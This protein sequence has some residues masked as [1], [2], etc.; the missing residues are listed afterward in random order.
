M[1]AQHV[2]PSPD[3]RSRHRFGVAAAAVATAV[4]LAPVAAQNAAD[5]VVPAGD[6][7]A[8]GRDAA[9]TKHSPLSDIDRTSV[10]RLMLAWEWRTGERAIDETDST[11]A[12][13][14]GTFQATPLAIDGILYLST[15]YN[16]VVALDGASGRELWR[17]DPG[18]FRHGQPSNGTGFVHR[19]VA[20]WTDGTERRILLASRWQLIALDAATGR[21]IPSFG[22]AGIVDLTA[23]LARPI[24]RLHYT[25]TSPPVVWQDLVIV[26]NGVGDRL[27][28]PGDPGGDVQAFDARTGRRV[29]SFDPIPQPGRTGNETWEDGSW[30]TAGHTNVWAPMSVDEARGLV[31]LPVSTPSNDFYGGARKGDNLFA[32]SVVCLDA[33][34]GERRWHFQIAHHGVWDYDLPTAPV[35]ATVRTDAGARDVVVQLTKQG[36]AFVFDRVT[37]EPIWPIEERPV[38]QSD[39]PGERLA[40]TQPFPTKPAPFA[41]QGFSEDDVVDF[42]PALRALALR[43]VRPYRTGP[44][45]APPSRAGTILMPG[46]IGGSGWGGGA[47]DPRSNTLFV[48]ATNAPAVIRLHQPPPSDTILAAW[49]FDRG[50]SL[51]WPALT[52][53]DSAALGG[54]PRGIPLHKPPYGTLTAIDLATGEHRW[55]VPAGDEPDVR[56][57][58]LLAA[59][60]L[61]QLGTSGAPGPIVTAGG[62]VFLTGGGSVLYAHDADTGAVLWRADL[63]ANGYANPMTYLGRDGR[64]YIVIA[65][66]SGDDAVL[67]AFALDAPSAAPAQ[68]QAEIRIRADRVLDGRGGV[69]ED[70]IVTVEGSRIVRVER[71]GND[72]DV[73]YDLRGFTLMPG[74]IDTHVHMNWHFDSDGR[75]HDAREESPQQAILYAA[76]NAYATLMGGITTVQSLGAS[77]DGDLRDALA[78]GTLPG[79]RVLTSLRSLSDRTGTPDEIR[80]AVRRLKADRADVI[81]IF[82][83]ASIRDGGAATMSQAQLDAACGEARAQGLRSAVHAHGPESAQRAVRA[84]CTV[85]EHG[86][87]LDDAT[88]DLMAEHRTFYD[89]NIG[90]VLQNYLENRAQFEGVGNYDA[91]GFAHM[92]RAVPLALDAF[93][94]A[95]QRPGIRIVF[96]TDAVAGAHGRNF[97]EL[98]YRVQQG[99]QPPMA[100]IVSATSLA[101]ESLGLADRIG[102][103]APG[104]EGDLIAVPG[105]VLEDITALLRV[106]FVMKA[107]TVVRNTVSAIR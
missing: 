98:I 72:P 42:T 82:A 28:Y 22:D 80:A 71:A 90:L 55:Q 103:V 31:F 95:L 84:G 92:E 61:P 104:F 27:T 88:L 32:E 23:G 43:A 63:G 36:F 76:E 38:P 52:A 39:V 50:A 60:E 66:G 70:A 15:P 64:Q 49:A 68:A 47:F 7:V 34:T 97:E 89:P 1:A 10:G 41:R 11:R 93:R 75:T 87:L 24:N 99:G 12:A 6:W 83:S 101:A 81:K 46:L 67:K 73:D 14:P 65:T 91:E 53:E 106:A 5:S 102:V 2:R 17:Y 54:S 30:R 51:R 18:A 8:W 79:P 78:R 69:L 100:A 58:A 9:A 20:T 29:W 4:Q 59:L 3:G 56:S 74:G 86:A 44:L 25:N 85:I 40:P 35:L 16:Q 13:R 107:G 19:G 45:Y 94:R 57:H 96:G 62:L 48:K 105:N 33:R 21:P 26:G 37:G 77:L